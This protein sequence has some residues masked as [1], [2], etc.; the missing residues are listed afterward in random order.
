MIEEMYAAL[1]EGNPLNFPPLGQLHIVMMKGHFGRNPFTGERVVVNPQ[2]TVK[3]KPSTELKQ[4]LAS[5]QEE[6]VGYLN[7]K[8]LPEG[9]TNKKKK[10]KE[11]ETEDSVN[12]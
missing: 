11:K 1:A 9:R 8:Y 4:Q 3:F 10:Q 5:L 7:V 2:R 12:G 6:D